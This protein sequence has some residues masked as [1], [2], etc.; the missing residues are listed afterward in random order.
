MVSVSQPP[1][2]PSHSLSLSLSHHRSLF[3]FCLHLRVCR[4]VFIWVCACV[5]WRYPKKHAD[6]LQGSAT[7]CGLEIELVHSSSSHLVSLG[8]PCWGFWCP[9]CGETMNAAL[10]F[11]FRL[12]LPLLL[13]PSASHIH[14]IR[15]TTH[16]LRWAYAHA[17]ARTY[18]EWSAKRIKTTHLGHVCSLK[19][20]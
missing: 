12:S 16:P 11:F 14:V 2:C 3:L 19:S 6:L 7:R 15:S 4:C 1:R 10:R 9:S 5:F 18:V 20:T 13:F 17:H 8:L